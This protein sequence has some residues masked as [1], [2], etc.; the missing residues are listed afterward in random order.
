MWTASRLTAG[1]GKVAS[2][3]V[4]FLKCILSDSF[5]NNFMGRQKNNPRGP[6]Q[7]VICSSTIFAV[8]FSCVAELTI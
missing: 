4:S 3:C 8:L 6:P 5:R 1:N 7:N 2:W